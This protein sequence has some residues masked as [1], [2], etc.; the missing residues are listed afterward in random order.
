VLNIPGHILSDDEPSNFL[1]HETSILE[2]EKKTLFLQTDDAAANQ[3]FD[4]SLKKG[5]FQAYVQK[6][7]RNSFSNNFEANSKK[8]KKYLSLQSD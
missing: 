1:H 2:N 5:S 6:R 8:R 4:S 7:Y 3:L